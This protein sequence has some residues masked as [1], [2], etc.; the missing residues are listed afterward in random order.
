VISLAHDYVPQRALQRAWLSP[1]RIETPAASPV[2]AT[3]GGEAPPGAQGVLTAWQLSRLLADESEFPTV[4]LAQLEISQDVAELVPRAWAERYHLV[5]VARE[6]RTLRV[7]VCDALDD[8]GVDH[9]RYELELDIAKCLAPAEEIAEA[10]ARAYGESREAK[11]A[12]AAP[13]ELA[14][15]AETASPPA[16]ISAEAEAP[17]VKLVHDLILGAIRCRASDIH[18]EPLE[19]RFRVRYRV[20]GALLEA[21]NPPKHLQL[22]IISRLKIMANISIAEKRL[23]QDGRI[24]ITLGGR[25]MDLRVSSLPTVHGESIVMRILDRAHLR[26]GLA[27]LGFL[28]DDQARF[29][30]LVTLPD[31]LVLVTGPTGSGKTTTLYSSLHHLNQCNRKIV[32]VEDPVEYQLAGINQVPV[33][34]ECG[35]TFGSALRAMLRQAPNAIMVGEIRDRETAEIALHAALTGHMVFSTLHTNDATGAIARLEDM[36][37]KPYLLSAALRGVLAQRLV[38]RICP[39]CRRPAV[40]RAAE[41]GLL[42]TSGEE[43]GTATCWRGEGCAECRGTGYLGRTGIF[44]LLV[45]NEELQELIHTRVG[46]GRLRSKARSLGLRTMREDGLRKAIAGLTTIEEVVSIT[47]GDAS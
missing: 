41:L 14:L 30:Q 21:E 34:P 35:L 36:G 29:E 32:T 11:A 40:P 4:D 26:L 1:D 25:S 5:P 37:V 15:P 33:R 28:P 7:A 24:Q 27:E 46:S 19:R 2:S 8:T 45:V 12:G 17:V 10:I 38:R 13:M 42:G 22:P 31:G 44:E 3:A 18:L 39:H 16:C 43:V 6:G 47:A 23:P 20:D 9:L